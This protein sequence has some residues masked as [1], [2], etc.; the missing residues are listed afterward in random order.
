MTDG[1]G[2]TA[3]DSIVYDTVNDQILIGVG[4]GS[5]W[6]PDVRDPNSDGDNLFL[7]RFLRLMRIRVNIVGTTKL[8]PATAGITL[9]H[10]RS[11][12]PICRWERGA[13][14]RVVMQAPKNGSSMCSMLLMVS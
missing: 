3:W 9:R 6:N 14:R 10:N 8:P 13:S 2:G 5:P 11:C 12:W 1:G 7:H 4:N